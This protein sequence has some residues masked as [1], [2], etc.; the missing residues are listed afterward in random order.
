MNS[1]AEDIARAL[2]DHDVAEVVGRGQYGIVWRGHHRQLQ[3]SVAIKQL[4]EVTDDQANRFRREARIL[5]QLDHPHVVAVYDY[6]EVDRLR[7]L[8][9]ELL[10]GGT[11][12]D[13]TATEAMSV[14]T[15]V[16]AT[17]AVASGLHHVHE[18]GVLHRD[19]KPENLMFDRRGTLKI[20]DFGVARN[21][22]ADALRLT[23]TNDRALV[24]T[25]AYCS[26]EQAGRMLGEGWPEATAATDQYSLA[27]VLYH[28]LS[29]ELTHDAA[30]GVVGL[31]TRR[32]TGRARPL[33]ASAPAVP[34]AIVA[35]IM[36]AL[37]TQPADRH[38]ST[39]AF[40][41]AL[42]SA[43]RTSLGADWLSR[44]AVT[45]RSVGPILTAATAD[46]SIDRSLTRT[47]DAGLLGATA[48]GTEPT[49]FAPEVPTSTDSAAVRRPGRRVARGAAAIIV[50]MLLGVAVALVATQRQGKGGGSGPTAP[51]SGQTRGSLEEVWTFPAG[52][53]VFSSPAVA[54]ST[55]VVGS[56]GGS[57]YGLEVA[58]GAK[59]WEHVTDGPVVSSPTID[60][61]V[62]YIGGTDG[63]LY[64]LDLETGEPRWTATIGFEVVARPA[65]SDGLVVVGSDRLYA[66]DASSGERRWTFEPDDPIVSSAAIDGGTVVVGSNDHHVYGIS[67]ADGTER[68]HL[69]TGD[70]VQSSPTI[71]DG[72]AY[73]GGNDGFLYAISVATGTTLWGVDLGSPVRSS[74]AVEGETVVVGTGAGE[75]VGVATSDGTEQWLVAVGGGVSSSP[76]AVPGGFLVGTDDG[77]VHLVSTTGTL[78]DELRTGGPV[79]S[80]PTSADDGLAIVGSDDGKVYAVRSAVPGG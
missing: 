49:P 61:G 75:L 26:P 51:G 21:E 37:E 16:A 53:P 71:V 46:R 19:V 7:L 65:V 12:A 55:T 54:G 79:G 6:R 24:G 45:V 66:F 23:L 69:R 70:A 48:R 43:A 3:R 44:S 56:D 39:E 60:G 41:V 15:A 50:V 36:R 20:T 31:C 74:P 63:V 64:A 11:L 33:E 8:I 10:D 4:A 42:A 78:L 17:L 47:A 5:A 38:P 1:T 62:V 30:G 67:L 59:R 29:G 35:A 2:P 72:T 13:R 73:L 68:W 18:L 27:A 80:S 14:E 52:G 25:P 57:V 77:S 9:M 28:L 58:T 32:M 34:P 40:G 22:P 76:L